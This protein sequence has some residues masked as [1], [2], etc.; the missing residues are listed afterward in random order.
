[1]VPGWLRAAKPSANAVLVY[2]TLAA[3]GCFNTAEG[4]YEECR[5]PLALIAED[6]GTSESTVKRA[7]AELLRLKAV[8]RTERW[9]EDG[10]TRLPSVY[11]VVFGVIAGPSGSTGGP[12]PPVTG[13]PRG[14][15]PVTHNPEPPTQSPP[16]QKP[17]ASQRGTRLPKDWRPSEDLLA[18]ARLNAPAV[19]W[20]E[21]ERFVDYFL[22]APGQR[23]SKVDWEATW[24]NWMRRASEEKRSGR[25]A[26]PFVQQADEYRAQKAAATKQRDDA[27]EALLEANPGMRATVAARMVDEEIAKR[28]DGRTGGAYIEG[29]ATSGTAAPEVTA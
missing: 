2:V 4:V 5:P 22:G 25:S 11:R 9:A 3:Y 24:R 15:S 1:M 12:T 7:L 28:V 14:G 17:S 18:W 21:H 27:V 23:G 13:E 6:S 26:K 16:T 19:G 29:V 8:E 20:A 10:K